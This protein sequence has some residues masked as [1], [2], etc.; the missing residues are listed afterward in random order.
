MFLPDVSP[1]L[2]TSA[3]FFPSDKY[4]RVA[5]GLISRSVITPSSLILQSAEIVSTANSVQGI[6]YNVYTSN[7]TLPG[8]D[9]RKL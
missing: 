7:Y 9:G 5:Q 2:T 1:R 8:L 6:V 4:D 3:F